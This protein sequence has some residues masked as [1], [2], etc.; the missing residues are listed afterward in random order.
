MHSLNHT[1]FVS[2]TA[3]ERQVRAARQRRNSAREHPPPMRRV[4]AALT[5]RVA[6][7]LDPETARRAIA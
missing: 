3:A 5:A 1:A 7:R 2:A 4:A 6:I